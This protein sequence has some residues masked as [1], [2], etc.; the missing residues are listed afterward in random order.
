MSAKTRPEVQFQY[1]FVSHN[2]KTTFNL[3]RRLGER[4][5]VGSVVA[6]VGELGCGKTLFTKGVCVGLGIPERLVN[7]PTF[8]FVN[9]YKGR[10]PVF[11]IDLYRL[12]DLEDS[13][14]IGILDYLTRAKSGVIIVE[15]AEKIVSLLSESYLKVQFEVLGPRHRQMTITG[16]GNFA[17]W[18]KEF[19]G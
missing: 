16:Y 6:L 18:L 7:S 17:R 19:T 13:L 12:T 1:I 3:G 9:E 11:H 5:G 14:G 15:W 8:A 2:P 10:L 4:L